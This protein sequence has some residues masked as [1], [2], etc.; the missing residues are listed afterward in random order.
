[1][2]SKDSSILRGIVIGSLRQSYTYEELLLKI[3]NADVRRSRAV[4]SVVYTGRVPKA[5]VAAHIASAVINEIY[6]GY[7]FR[8]LTYIIISV[9]KTSSRRGTRFVVSLRVPKAIYQALVRAIKILYQNGINVRKWSVKHTASQHPYKITMF[10]TCGSPE[11][12]VQHV[13]HEMIRTQFLKLVQT[14]DR[15]FCVTLAVKTRNGVNTRTK[16]FSV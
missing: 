10:A 8:K 6:R 7:R 2:G 12:N 15:P 13:F 1:M 14:I 5:E 4:I 9:S 11:V 3:V 16:C